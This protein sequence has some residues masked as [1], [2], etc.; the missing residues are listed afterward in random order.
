MRILGALSL[1][2]ILS[3][4]FGAGIQAVESPPLCAGTA[5]LRTR[6]AAALAEDGGA[7]SL[8]TGRALIATLDAGCGDA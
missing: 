2:M 7:A 5:D 3:G 8:S 1:P 4:C 6:H